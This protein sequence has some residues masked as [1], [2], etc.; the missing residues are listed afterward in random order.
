M[1]AAISLTG[2]LAMAGLGCA[3]PSAADWKSDG[4][5]TYGP[6]E[7]VGMRSKPL[8]EMVQNFKSYTQPANYSG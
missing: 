4:V 8:R 2:C 6:P 5:L 3:A 1:R 7:S